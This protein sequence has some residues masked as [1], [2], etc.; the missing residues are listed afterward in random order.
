LIVHAAQVG[1]FPHYNIWHGLGK[2]NPD[3]IVVRGPVVATYGRHFAFVT[4]AQY[5]VA[6]NVWDGDVSNTGVWVLLAT[7]NARSVQDVG[8]HALSAV[9]FPSYRLSAR[10]DSS[11]F[12]FVNVAGELFCCSGSDPNGAWTWKSLGRPELY[13]WVGPPAAT[14]WVNQLND[15]DIYVFVR[16]MDQGGHGH[17]FVCKFDGNLAI[18]W[19]DVTQTG[20]PP[21][22]RPPSA[23]AFTQKCNP[24]PE[25]WVGASNRQTTTERR[26]EPFLTH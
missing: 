3:G 8:L 19:T 11:A 21:R 23:K 5:G 7:P 14:V 4:Y 12:V 2:Q 25:G 26:P 10:P 17:L 22:N 16:G 20:V 13:E 24:R 15:S 1:Y 18:G 6:V 9:I